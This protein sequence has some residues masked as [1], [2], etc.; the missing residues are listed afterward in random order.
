MR[1]FITEKDNFLT[2]TEN[3]KL[4]SIT[5]KLNGSKMCCSL[6][7]GYRVA[8]R[9]LQQ[10][11]KNNTEEFSTSNWSGGGMVNAKIGKLGNSVNR[12]YLNSRQYRFKSCP[13]YKMSP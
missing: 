4:G 3:I 2:N 9:L 7:K 10:T 12:S 11:V 8:T 13:D 5:E 6:E 1:V